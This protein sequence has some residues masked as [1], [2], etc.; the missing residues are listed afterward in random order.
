MEVC[1]MLDVR[2]SSILYCNGRNIYQRHFIFEKIKLT[3]LESSVLNSCPYNP[4]EHDS[5]E[6]MMNAYTQFHNC[7]KG[8]T[9]AKYIVLQCKESEYHQLT[10]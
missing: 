1:I 3:Q 6:S 2:L 7:A 10:E 8:R 9:G 5:L 4:N